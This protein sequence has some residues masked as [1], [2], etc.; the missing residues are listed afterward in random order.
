M[1][2]IAGGAPMTKEAVDRA[3]ER[4]RADQDRISTALLDLDNHVGHRLLDSADLTGLTRRRWDEARAQ[5][6][7][8]W[9]LFDAYGRTL[10]DAQRLRERKAK[11]DPPALE[12]LTKLLTGPVV[13]PD[14]EEIPLQQRTL[15]GPTQ[16]TLT[17]DAA[18]TEMTEAY[19][20]ATEMVAAADAAW[21]VLLARIAE[22]DQTHKSVTELAADLGVHP[23]EAEQ[24][25]ARLEEL[26]ATVQGDP[27]SFGAPGQL[28]TRRFDQ[29]AAA[30]ATLENEL[31]EARRARDEC[32]TRLGG[33]TTT[34]DRIRETYD[35]TVRA[36]E[37][38][39]AKIA[40]PVLPE[41]PDVLADL[42]G[43]LDA[44]ALLRN[45]GRWSELAGRMNDLER[46]TADGLRT[47]EEVFQAIAGLLDRRNELRG[48]LEAYR[49]KAARLGH[50]E[51]TDLDRL[52]L[53]ARQLLWSAPCDL[54]AATVAVAT[55]QRAVGSV[56]T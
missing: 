7:R 15:L 47:A 46:A 11:P 14:G 23:P 10:E 36:R 26:R 33:L 35:R 38:V 42:T 13:V 9:R 22:L 49:A 52:Y 8:L 48:R 51:D 4:L 16:A 21:S 25:A 30:Y 1:E 12:H 18:V 54:G 53:R 50:A 27:L 44:L 31:S 5:I 24:L 6:E 41:Q 29:L 43:R 55:Y 45:R 37:A 28:D 40:D 17:L 32:E 34:L 56:S 2:E 3:L 20:R 19:D 39:L